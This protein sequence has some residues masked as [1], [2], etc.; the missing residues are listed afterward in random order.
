MLSDVLETNYPGLATVL[1]SGASGKNSDFGVA[2]LKRLVIDKKPDALLIEY[3]I[4]DCVERFDLSV[5]K[6]ESNLLTIVN[7]T[8][9][10]YPDCEIILMTMTPGDKYE[11][12]H[13]SYRKNIQAYY[14][15]YRRVA[16]DRGYRL[17]DH[18]SSWMALQTNDVARFNRYV[19]DTIH[20]RTE[21]NE[22][23]V[24]PTLI[25]VLGIKGDP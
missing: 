21:G 13:T 24:M 19:P 7:Q 8:L 18:Y 25:D 12:G 4:N 5:E 1:N 14:A 22:I 11:P 20:P 15:M 17:I 3:G 9:A 10:S 16:Q 2:N 6:A 23:V